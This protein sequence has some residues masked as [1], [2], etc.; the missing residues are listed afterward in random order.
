[1]SEYKVVD[2]EQLDSDL[3]S[4]ADEI[5]NVSGTTELL[6]FP[7]GFKAS[8]KNFQQ[9][10]SSGVVESGQCGENAIWEFYEDGTLVISGTGALEGDWMFSEEEDIDWWHLE[11]KVTKIVVN[12]GITDTGRRVLSLFAP[13][14]TKVELPNS[15]ITIGAQTFLL[16]EKLT[17]VSIPSNV[18]SIGIN[19]F[20][21]SGVKNIIIPDSVI[22]IGDGAFLDC[23]S[24]KQV[25]I[26]SGVTTIGAGVFE[27]TA[28]ENITIPDGVTSIGSNAFGSANLT[29][30]VLGRGITS[31]AETAFYSTHFLKSIVIPNTV[32]EINRK[33]FTHFFDGV[34]SDIDLETVYFT[35]TKEEWDSI[36]IAEGNEALFNATLYCEYD[37]NADTVDGWNVNVITDDSD[38]ENITEPTITFMY[39]VGG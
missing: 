13:N 20:Q 31:I 15:L 10:G 3:K 30:I 35:G 36:T 21:Q 24:L 16:C 19:A 1:M 8:I 12:E 14:L 32:T 34:E 37:P 11:D 39:T 5:R 6:D 18:I 33:A 22:S 17:N 29:H 4:V 28:I 26:G 25:L 23:E 2:A 27:G 38:I 7:E 9:G